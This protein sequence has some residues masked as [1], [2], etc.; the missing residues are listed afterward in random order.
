MDLHGAVILFLI[1][2]PVF[3]IGYVCG[4]LHMRRNYLS[5]LNAERRE[6]RHILRYA[7]Q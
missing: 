7:R 4:M 5:L 3:G 2:L 6:K 1:F